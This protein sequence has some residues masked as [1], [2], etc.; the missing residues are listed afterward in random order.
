MRIISTTGIALLTAAVA[1]GDAT[2]DQKTQVHFGGAMSIVNV[3]GGKATREGVESTVVVKGDR[4]SSRNGSSGEIVDL[5]A[6]KIYRIDYDRKSYKV[7]TFDELRKQFE[8]QKARAEKEAKNKK[9]EEGTELE[10]DFDH[11]STGKKQTINGYSTHEEVVTVTVREK[12]KKLEQSGGWVLTADMWVGPKIAAMSEMTDFD[13]RYMQKL[14]GKE[15]SGADMSAMMSALAAT[16]AFAKAMKTFSEK[17]GN[18]DGSPIRTLLTFETVSAPGQTADRDSEPSSA[19]AAAI[20]GLFNKLQKKR[21][22]EPAAD[23]KPSDPN[24]SKLFDS[25]VELLKASPSA[26]ASDVAIPSDFKQTR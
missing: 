3:F 18:F 4:K 9:K 6:E 26:A 7:T 1:F 5:A 23:T 25:T 21:Q 20:G 8:E 11:K 19:A 13:R 14:Y 22:A 2:V 24:R 17:R 12:G 15:F 10:V 16:P